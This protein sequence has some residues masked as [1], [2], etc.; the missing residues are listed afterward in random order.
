M[1]DVGPNVRS[2][3][4]LCV[5][6]TGGI[7]SGKSYVAECFIELGVPVLDADHVAREV[8]MPGTSGLQSIVDS[9]GAAVLAADGS[10][11]RPSMRRRVFN[12]V[13]ALRRLE[14]ITHPLIRARV[15]QWL[16]AQTAPYSIYSA[17]ILVESGMDALVDRV[18]VVDAPEPV[19]IARLLA[20]DRH[21]EALA[22][23]MLAVQ[24]TRRT[25]LARADDVLDNSAGDA[26]ILPAVQRLHRFYLQLAATPEPP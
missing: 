14:A 12:D 21:D 22:R 5:G 24:A 7:A 2:G 8:V 16:A 25:R 9:F 3:A 19:Q 26:S 4:W 11:D 23:R 6:L 15:K 18:L 13:A 20:R 1:P 17:P 10:L